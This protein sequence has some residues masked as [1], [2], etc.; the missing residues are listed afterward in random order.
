VKSVTAPIAVA[1]IAAIAEIRGLIAL[2]VGLY[3]EASGGFVI[4]EHCCY[5]IPDASVL[6]A[7]ADVEN[8]WVGA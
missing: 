6:W 5:C 3:V 8:A 7:L 1:A 2:E 4:G